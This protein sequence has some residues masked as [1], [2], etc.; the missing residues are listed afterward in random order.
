[1]IGNLPEKSET[2]HQIF[3]CKLIAFGQV[4]QKLRDHS[5]INIRSSGRK[6]ITLSS[7]VLDCLQ[8]GK[9]L[10]D[11]VINGYA[12]LVEELGERG[13]IVFNSFLFFKI[14]REGYTD[15]VKKQWD[16]VSN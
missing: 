13:V 12:Q 9:W 14:A 3:P 15:S 1:L 10:N 6:V 8:P 16:K 2:C 7:K 5:R 11:E 4:K